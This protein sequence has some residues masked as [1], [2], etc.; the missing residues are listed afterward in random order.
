MNSNMYFSAN[1]VQNVDLRDRN[2]NMKVK[3]ERNR[4]KELVEQDRN[5]CR[6]GFVTR[7]EQK[8]RNA[9]IR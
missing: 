6:H 9:S 2:I 8:H 3:Q 1:T 4:N 5:I 7:K